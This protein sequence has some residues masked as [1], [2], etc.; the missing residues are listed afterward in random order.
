MALAWGMAYG[1]WY[2][3]GLGQT[4]TDQDTPGRRAQLDASALRDLRTSCSGQRK[5]NVFGQLAGCTF[6]SRS[7]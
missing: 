7:D 4:R 6:E 3:V 2:S 1:T 5:K